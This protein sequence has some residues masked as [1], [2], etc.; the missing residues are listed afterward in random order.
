MSE[1]FVAPI[2]S[3]A[4]QKFKDIVKAHA[5]SGG[6][7]GK[8]LVIFCE[9]RLSLVAERAV[10]EVVG[11]T[12][13]V[14]VTTLSRFLSAE[15][16]RAENVLSSEASAMAI[17]KLIEKNKESLQ[18][19]KMLS[20]AG[21]AQEV[22]DTIALLYSSRVTPDILAEVETDGKL[23]KR[24][25]HDLE[26]LY[27]AYSEYLAE[28]GA[29]D[30]NVYLRRVPEVI[31]SSEK[32]KG[33]DVTFFGFQ[34]LT[35]SVSDCVRAAF[36]TADEVSGVFIGGAQNK[37]VNE[38]WTEFIKIANEYSADNK[39]VNLPSTSTA[40]AEH[41]RRYLFEPECFNKSVSKGISAGQLTI[42]AANDEDEECAFIAAQILKCVKEDGVRYREISVMLPDFAI[43]QHALERAF[44][45][46]SVPYY[47]DR[48][49]PLSSHPICAFL[50]DFL[51]CAADG[52]RR[53]S[54]FSVVNSPL[55]CLTKEHSSDTDFNK[56]RGMFINYM[57][58]AANGRG[59]VFK[60][61]NPDI[62]ADEHN[63]DYN[64]I[65]A[66][67][68][69]FVD[70]VKLIR[71]KEKADCNAVI[72]ALKEILSLY[73]VEERL[74][75]VETVGDL[76][77][78]PTAAQMS[79]RAYEATLKVLDEAKSL[80]DGER[81]PLGELAKILKSGFVA[82]EISLI[83]PKQDAVFVSDLTACANA[84]SKVVFVAGLT[85]SVPAAS[86]DTAIL[87]D[88]E[89]VSLERLKVDVSPKISQVNRRVKEITALNVCA[90][91]NKLFLTYPT[92]S[93]G[94]EGGVSEILSYVSHLFNVGGN[95][96]VAETV[97]SFIERPDFFAYFN[98]RP[99]PALRTVASY[100]GGSDKYTHGQI[101]AVYRT[102]LDCIEQGLAD[103]NYT[104][105]KPA[106]PDEDF[107]WGKLYGSKV[108][109]TTLETYFSCPFKA[110]M[111]QGI[112]L[113]E[114]RE[115]TFRPLDSGNFIHKVLE[116]VAKELNHTNSREECAA[117]AEAKARELLGKATY[118]TSPEDG[119]ATYAAGALVDEAVQVSL[120]M[121]DQLKNSAFSVERTE[122]G[123]S[124][125]LGGGVAVGGR[126][127]RTDAS[128]DMV[129]IIDYKTGYIDDSPSSYYLGLKLQ[130]PL[131]L[132]AVSEGRRAAGAY[133]FP[134]NL[135]YSED[136]VGAFAL[137]GFMD[138]SEDVVKASDLTLQDKEKSAYVGAYLNGRKLDKAMT[139]EDFADFLSY[140]RAIS[141]VGASSL[142]KGHIAPSPIS[143][144]CGRC[145]FKGSCG[146]DVEKLGEREERKADCATIAKI[147][148][149][150]GEERQ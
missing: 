144:A 80:T 124:I 105:S 62:C 59:A 53:D 112:R 127:D 11:G 65:E 73:D 19:F 51:A 45:E 49:Y 37:Y 23:L 15:E 85:E 30:R 111:Q 18:L 26:F 58:R 35:A 33:A 118:L 27:R 129:R 91:E 131:Y 95:P 103:E 79:A 74:K 117:L 6:G 141:S 9:D 137:K 93:G 101:F 14:Q 77:N 7:E 119:S 46:Y 83:Q 84:G 128:G 122:Q 126:I 78:R 22:Y 123:C 60:Q 12:F 108:S 89:L 149:G 146:Y 140:S 3:T 34:A 145:R 42:A 38:A 50:C 44:G 28:T 41:L 150:D 40:A 88:S 61:I 75:A 86:Q 90:F 72:S 5:E 100:L 134:A 43:Y 8:R 121:Y 16:G 97:E 24:K 71:G 17:R 64:S 87:T 116:L 21:A 114:R 68:Q 39:I 113:E 48:R 133:Y 20:T 147:A 135:E 54:V 70:G 125:D 52:C 13:A 132:S 107:D 66:V 1:V 47:V 82:A 32:I 139:R 69:S 2:L 57:L 106:D 104:V 76:V 81:M 148:R 56:D 4:L 36:E 94:E 63:F 130:L 96:L 92:R 138:G 67:R 99:A 142:S 109:P 98:C 136:G 29:V 115:G 55:F 10:C 143:D 110:F 31:R 102:L 25:L 120:G